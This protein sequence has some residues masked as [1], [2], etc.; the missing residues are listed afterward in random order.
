MP[1][2]IVFEWVEIGVDST[3]CCSVGRFVRGTAEARDENS[4]TRT[5]IGQHDQGAQQVSSIDLKLEYKQL[6]SLH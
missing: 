5:E 2:R 6:H 3:N 4:N 1:K